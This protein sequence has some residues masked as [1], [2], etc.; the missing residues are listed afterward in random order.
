[1]KPIDVDALEQTLLAEH[2]RIADNGGTMSNSFKR[3]CA[4]E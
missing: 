1:M 2:K 3:V 4:W